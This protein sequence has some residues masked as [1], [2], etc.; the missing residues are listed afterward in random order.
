MIINIGFME[1]PS[2]NALLYGCPIIEDLHLCF[3]PVC[4]DKVCAPPSLKRLKFAITIDVG[5][6][7][8]IDA[9]DLEYLAV[10]RITFG[11]VFSM[12]NLHNVV[13]AY[14]DVFPQ[15]SGS[16]IPLHNL[17]NAL[18]RIKRLTLSHSTTKV[19]FYFMVT[20][21]FIY[22]EQVSN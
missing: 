19:K 5:A 4:L 10:S 18:P 21:S 1:V 16:V 22:K 13:T 14:L 7:L 17:L 2:V 6:Y 11:K 20:S 12:Y 15:P 8:E 9:P 3:N